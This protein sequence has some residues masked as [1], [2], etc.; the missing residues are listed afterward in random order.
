MQMVAQ[1]DERYL[2]QLQVGQVA[3]ALADAYPNQRF[4]LKVESIS[5]LIDAQRGA[6]QVKFSLLQQ[7]PAFLRE[8]MTLSIEV[9][10][11]RRERT[12]VVPTSAVRDDAAAGGKVVFIEHD[13]RVGMR[14]VRLGLRTLNAVEV[15]D[16]LKEG[17]L[18]LLATAPKVGARVHADTMLTAAAPLRKSD[19]AGSA[20]SNAMGR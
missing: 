20:M 13:G 6:I 3:T 19:D 5:P 1:V 14:K 10:T 8:D 11:A 9:E 4:T 18:V 12:L 2:E 17:D 16:G 15:L 7:A